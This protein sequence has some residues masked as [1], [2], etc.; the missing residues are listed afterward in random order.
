[1][2]H[3]PA[4]RA[5]YLTPTRPLGARTGTEELSGLALGPRLLSVER[6]AGR[7]GREAEARVPVADPAV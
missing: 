2:R 6:R 1:M 7:S 5:S 3:Q 4:R